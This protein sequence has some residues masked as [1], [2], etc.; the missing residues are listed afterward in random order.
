MDKQE[1]EKFIMDMPDEVLSKIQFAVPWQ[2]NVI[3][4]VAEGAKDEDGFPIQLGV[5]K[6][7]AKA[8]REY[9]QKECWNK[10]HRNPQINTSVRGLTGRLTGWGY[11]TTSGIEKIQDAIEEI[12]LDPRNRL[13]SYWPKFVGRALIE[14]E[15]HLTFTCHS[16]GFI[17]VDFTD[18]ILISQHGK[19]DTGIIY[20]PT[21]TNFPLF[22]NVCDDQGRL[23]YQIPSINI[24]RY[25][26]LV[27][28]PATGKGYI[29]LT[30]YS[31]YDPKLQKNSRSRKKKFKAFGGY[32]RFMVSWDRGFI[33]R[34]AVSYLRTVLEWLNHYENLKKYEIDHK[35]AAGAYV[36]VFSFENPRD[37]KMW[38][39]LTDEERSKTAVLQKKTPGGSLVLPPGMTCEAKNPNLTS[40]K[41]QDTDIMQ[42]VTSGLNEAS[43]VT[44]GTSSGTFASVKASRGPMSDR[45][46]DEVADFDNFQKYDFWGSIFFLKSKIIDFPSHFSVNEAVSF[47]D[48]G[49]P[50]FKR[51]RIRPE[52]LIDISYPISETA[53]FEGRAKGLLGVKHGPVSESIGVPASEVAKRMGLGGWARGRLRKATEDKNYPELVYNVD[54]ESLQ[55]TVEG[56]PGKTKPKPKPKP[57]E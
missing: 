45:T 4:G 55:E 12:E 49:E 29:N 56:E 26:E 36:W 31:S 47:D 44:T 46:S 16:D 42:M 27:Q 54:A 19:D 30:D 3:D 23:A 25:P 11:E 40:I 53:N 57:K 18:P 13:F 21:K 22:Y 10:F 6:G 17:E 41:E 14:G 33:T 52:Q 9:L 8:T 20:H 7:D 34:R 28:L 43:D 1:V 32:Y 39:T 2:Y 48:K 5:K 51:K 15:L 35:K 50:V 38:L 37:F 24:A